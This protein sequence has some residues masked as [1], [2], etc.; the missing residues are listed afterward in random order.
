MLGNQERF[1][2]AGDAAGFIGCTEPQDCIN[3]M[4]VPIHNPRSGEGKAGGSEIQGHPHE[5]NLDNNARP[6]LKEGAFLREA[7]FDLG[8]VCKNGEIQRKTS[9]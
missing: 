6:C 7:D 1:L 4:V 8:H 9:L 5:A 3:S 2:E